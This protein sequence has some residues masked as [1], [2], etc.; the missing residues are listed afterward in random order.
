LDA[1]ILEDDYDAEHRY[2]GR[3]LEAVQ[4]LDRSGRVIYI[5]T[6]TTVLFPSLRLGYVVMPAPLRD[7]LSRAKWV[8]DRHTSSLQQAALAD[9]MPKATSITY[10]RRFRAHSASRRVALLE[11]IEKNF[12][13]GV[14]VLEPLPECMF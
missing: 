7:A 8:A 12:G 9:F 2:E 4:G 14:E 6:F 10:V 3:P 5:G 1:Y 13:D 11:A